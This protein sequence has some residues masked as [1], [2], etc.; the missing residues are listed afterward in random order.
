[1]HDP[2]RTKYATGV[3]VGE[4]L[5]YSPHAVLFLDMVAQNMMLLMLVLRN[6][7]WRFVW[8]NSSCVR[9]MLM[10]VTG[11][12][13]PPVGTYCIMAKDILTEEMVIVI[14]AKDITYSEVLRTVLPKFHFVPPPRASL[15][16][17]L[18][19]PFQFT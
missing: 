18:S 9:V 5:I 6:G 7:T 1:M 17:I 19:H 16:K 10:V 13:L 11:D 12:R 8:I 14:A 3:G 4:L 2:Q 15:A